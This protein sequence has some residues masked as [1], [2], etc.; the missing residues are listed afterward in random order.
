M[1][2]VAVILFGALVWLSASFAQFQFGSV[3]GQI[4]DPSQAPVPGATVEIKSQTTN[5][6]RRTTT[7]PSGDFNLISLPPDKYTIT[8]RHEGFREISRSLELSVDQRLEAD[9]T[10]EVGGVTEA[11][12]VTGAAPLLEVA[13]SELGDVRSEQQVEDLP[14][15][16]RNFTQ[17]VDLAPGVNNRGAS[18]NSI[19]QGYTSG[20]G[21]NGAVI[22]GA[23][24]EGGVYMFDGVQSV[25]NDAGMIIFLTPVDAIQEFKVQ[26]SSAGASYGGG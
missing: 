16:T 21:V 20:R 26:T 23:V 2:N 1:R 25:D 24:P 10:L 7:S 5:V 13:S 3:V 6:V 12:T 22:N 18:S 19:L 4:K 9:L 8:V 11:V 15:N 14:L 17:L